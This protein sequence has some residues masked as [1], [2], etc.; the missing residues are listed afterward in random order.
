MYS[1]QGNKNTSLNYINIPLIFQYMYDNGFRLQAGPQLGFLVKA[2]SEIANNQVDVKD[3]FESIDL[4][5]GVGMSYVN[6]A[7]NFGMDLRYNHGLSN[8]SKIDGTS[9][10]NRGFQVGVFYL[11]NHN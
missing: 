7:T 3:Q 6:P 9:V 8:I 5:L 11:F 2:E 1:M 4:A 10:Y